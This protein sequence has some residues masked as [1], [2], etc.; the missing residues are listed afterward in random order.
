V[1]AARAAPVGAGCGGLHDG[2]VGAAWCGAARRGGA[3]AAARACRARWALRAVCGAAAVVFL[4]RVG[5]AR[6]S[7]SGL[8]FPSAGAAAPVGGE[9][10][11][12]S[13][14]RT[15]IQTARWRGLRCCTAGCGLARSGGG[16]VQRGGARP[17][18]AEWS[19]ARVGGQ[20]ASARLVV[21]CGWP[22]WVAMVLH[23]G[24]NSCSGL[25][26]AG[27]GDGRHM[28]SWKHH[29]EVCTLLRLRPRQ[30]HGEPLVVLEHEGS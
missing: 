8:R 3:V 17:G 13:A 6:R 16:S 12:V 26:G 27:D 22:L 25:A 21:A 10:G 11:F 7:S 20:R 9:G 28:L 19:S 15:A 14:V 1:V 18:S 30:V 24:R 2:V 4:V 29:R 23:L 5:G